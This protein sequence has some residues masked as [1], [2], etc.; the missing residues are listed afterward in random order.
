MV[1]YENPEVFESLDEEQ[2]EVVKKMNFRVNMFLMRLKHFL[3][4]Y[5][6]IFAFI[7]AVLS[8]TSSVYNLTGG[9]PASLIFPIAITFII[10]AAYLY[11]KREKEAKA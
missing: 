3:S 8:I 6:I 5:Y 10:V 2:L 9:D 11:L 7:A 4:Q 1:Y